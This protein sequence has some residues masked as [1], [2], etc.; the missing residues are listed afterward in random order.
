MEFKHTTVLLDETIEYLNIDPSGVYLDATLGAGG[1]S[2]RILKELGPNGTLISVDID[3]EAVDFCRNKFKNENR[4]KIYNS[5]FVF[6]D[7]ILKN[8]GIN[9]INGICIDLGVSSYQIDCPE[10]GFSYIH[11]G[12]LD[13]RMGQSG[14]TAYDVVNFYEEN[15]LSDI[16]F[17]YGEEKNH[18]RIA[19]EICKFRQNQKIES[20]FDLVKI[21]EKVV[22][23]FKSGHSAKRTFQAIRIEVNNELNNLDITL[24]KCIN[25]LRPGGRLLV[26][27]FHSLEDRIVKQK[28][29]YWEKSCICPPELPICKCDKIQQV[30]LINK[31]II[32]ASS[33]E[34]EKNS[35]SKSAKLRIC[36]KN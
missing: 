30:R 27:S 10:R 32:T 28:M 26:L 25:L 12:R 9:K 7:E 33:S 1:L 19:R 8:E 15:K 31:K 23:K 6:I 24:D 17:K 16:I 35:R 5:N 11:N 34:I 2:E 21:I 20:T 14:I 4:I 29:K 22:P 3:K 13:M 36:E 18:R